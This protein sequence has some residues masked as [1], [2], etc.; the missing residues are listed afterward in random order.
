MALVSVLAKV[1]SPKQEQTTPSSS[2]SKHLQQ[3]VT[4]QSSHCNMIKSDW[5]RGQ[6]RVSRRASVL[7]LSHSSLPQLCSKHYSVVGSV[8]AAGDT[9]ANRIEPAPAL[10]RLLQY[11]R[12]PKCWEAKVSHAVGRDHRELTY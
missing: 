11:H 4:A 3:P 8:L 10:S 9:V 6:A 12:V 7:F 2:K 5:N 1:Q